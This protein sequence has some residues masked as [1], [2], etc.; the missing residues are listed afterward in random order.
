[1]HSEHLAKLVTC[2]VVKNGVSHEC[3]C[4]HGNLRVYQKGAEDTSV[5]RILLLF[6]GYNVTEITNTKWPAIWSA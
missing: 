6:K 5:G 2:A 3:Q 4:R 1:M